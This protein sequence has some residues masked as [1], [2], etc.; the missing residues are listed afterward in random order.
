MSSRLDSI[1]KEYRAKPDTELEFRFPTRDKAIFEVVL[2]FLKSKLKEDKD[3]HSEIEHSINTLCDDIVFKTSDVLVKKSIYVKNKRQEP[4]EVYRKG[5]EF[6]IKGEGWK[7]VLSR[8][9]KLNETVQVNINVGLRRVRIKSRISFF[10]PSILPDWRFDLTAV[11]TELPSDDLVRRVN[12]A[13]TAMFESKLDNFMQT[14]EIPEYITEYEI[15]IEHIGNRRNLD[16]KTLMGARDTVLSKI[17][18]SGR[19]QMDEAIIHLTDVLRVKTIPGRALTIKAVSNSVKDMTKNIY[20]S[21]VYPEINNYYVT[22]KADGDRA[23]IHISKRKTT[24]IYGSTVLEWPDKSKKGD[25]ILD[26]ELII[27]GS[28]IVAYVFD[29][30]M[31][32]GENIQNLP[33]SERIERIPTAIKPL[34]KKAIPKRYIRLSKDELSV[35][36]DEIM[37][38][39]RRYDIDGLIFNQADASYRRMKVWKYKPKATVD[40]LVRKCPK[41]LL[42]TPGFPEKRGQVLMLLFCGI[43]SKAMYQRGLTLISEYD[44]LFPNVSDDYF[45]IQF[46][47]STDPNAFIYYSHNDNLDGKVCEF[48]YHTSKSWQLLRVREDR[49][50]DI[51]SGRYFGNDFRVA[52]NILINAFNPLT[53]D[54]LKSPSAT[55]YFKVAPNSIYD[56]N[57]KYN[58][59]IRYLLV[60]AINDS[61]TRSINSVLDLACGTGQSLKAIAQVMEPETYFAVDIDRD[62]IGILLSRKDSILQELNDSR[63]RRA[64]Y[65]GRGELHDE[66]GDGN[67]EDG[68]DDDNDG[69]DS[70]SESLEFYSDSSSDEDSKTKKGGRVKKSKKK[71]TK[72]SKKE[73][74]NK[75]NKKHKKSKKEEKSTEIKKSKVVRIKKRKPGIVSIIGGAPLNIRTQFMDLSANES[76]NYSQLTRELEFDGADFIMFSYAINYLWDSNET[77]NNIMKF[78]SRCLNPG[79]RVLITCFDGNNVN[80]LLKNGNYESMSGDIKKYSIQKQYRGD[81]LERYGQQIGVLLPFSGDGSYYT[82][83]LVNISALISRAEKNGLK[84]HTDVY[85]GRG[86]FL[87]VE[88][89]IKADLRPVDADDRTYLNLYSFIILEKK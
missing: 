85:D 62:A 79:G 76:V 37:K 4:T 87:D 24:I 50:A 56:V 46:S 67:D 42:D 53:M 51:D 47:P 66:D 59:A 58:R 12:T 88:D 68:D 69:N 82:E 52:E 48:V 33:F 57:R 83:Y 15:E 70:D 11:I 74:K 63:P 19:S 9:I 40:L 22:D 36:L 10:I 5:R 45:P 30:L 73:E 35:Q 54:I 71:D 39:N 1:F 34:G 3:A 44:K 16:E 89:D 20:I 27:N 38:I 86:S 75:K 17:V 2:D 65:R 25:T 64:G 60:R 77:I 81:K 28:E 84:L 8:E 49:Q 31:H 61:K 43:N 13:R 78:I 80:N 26:S 23:F 32:D 14:V 72:K 7:L 6:D 21:E 18:S 55:G 29:V 41:N